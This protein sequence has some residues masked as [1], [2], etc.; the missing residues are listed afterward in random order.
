MSV[1]VFDLDQSNSASQQVYAGGEGSGLVGFQVWPGSV[2]CVQQPDGSS[3]DACGNL[4]PAR[5]QLTYG[6]SKCVVCMHV[7][8]SG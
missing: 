7:H 3:S 2:V 5:Q 1:F 6:S 4:D 8:A